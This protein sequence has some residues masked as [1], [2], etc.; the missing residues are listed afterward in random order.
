MRDSRADGR[1]RADVLVLLAFNNVLVDVDS[2]VQIASTQYASAAHAAW[3]RIESSDRASVMDEFFV[4]LAQERPRVSL[5]D[6]RSSAEQLPFST[7]LVD[8]IRLAVDAFGASCS[9][10]DDTCALSV[11]SFLQRHQLE[12]QV[13]EVVA[14]PTHFEDGGK[15]LRVRPYQ[16]K[17]V[18]PHGCAS[19]PANLCKGAVLERM[20]QQHRFSRVLYVGD[21][22][23]DFCVASK[24]SRNDVVFARGGGVDEV[25]HGLL[26]LLENQSDQVQA[27]V[28]EWKTGEDVLAFFTS[29]F[30]QQ[31]PACRSLTGSKAVADVA[32]GF[33]VPR[34]ILTE[35]GELLVIFDFDD[36][37]VNEDSDVFV[38]GSF[39]PELCQTVYERH[40]QK[41]V[42][43]SVF[44]DMLQVLSKEKP[45]VTPELIRD[46]VAQI[47]VQARM[48]DAIRMA[49]E[50]FGADVKVISDGNTFYIESML[51]HRELSEHVK[52][53]FAN[54]V[55]FEP[56]DDGRTRLRIRPYHADLL[57]PHG[58][59]WC[60]A[61]MCKGSILDAIRSTKPYT[62]VIYVG[63]GTGDFCPVSR[64]TR[65]VLFSTSF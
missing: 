38:F 42:W 32:E 53:V 41:P 39:H 22:A 9:V 8:A 60:P 4:Q 25:A 18:A 56:T 16:G 10:L 44:D 15:V 64:L 65:Y 40:A 47:P 1:P 5:E 24:L 28:I 30:N 54:P 61:N 21:G 17:H 37:L 26:P 14:N 3:S 20:L 33:E 51:Q 58:C 43:P 50:Q 29:F 12:H 46:R 52:E 31:Y 63:D 45:H 6:I 55:D 7:P 13:D 11:R 62:R 34:P 57:E 27:Q 23:A 2:D 19:C 59:E 36:S 48:L 49:V 35:P